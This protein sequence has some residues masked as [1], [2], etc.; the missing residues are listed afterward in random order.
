[1]AGNRNVIS[2]NTNNGISLSGVG[3]T[4]AV[5]QGNFV[6]VTPTGNSSMGNT[7]NGIQVNNSSD[8]LIGGTVTGLGNVISG[9]GQDGIVFDGNANFNVTQG[10][11]IGTN[12]AGTSA[13]GNSDRGILLKGGSSN[14]LIGGTTAGARNIVSGN[15]NSGIATANVN[16]SGNVI[17]GNYIGTNI[18]GSAA[19]GNKR[20]LYIQSD[21]NIIGGAEAGSGNLISGNSMEG[22]RLE[23]S[24]QNTI[25]GNLIGTAASGTAALGN[26]TDGIFLLDSTDTSIGGLVST[27]RNVISGNNNGIYIE[28][29][30]DIRVLGNYI[31]TDI[32]GS[33]D[34]GNSSNGVSLLNTNNNLIGGTSPRARNVISGNDSNG[35]L[36]ADGSGNT[37]Q[38]NFIGTTRTGNAALSNAQNGISLSNSHSNQIGG[39]ASGS[40]NII[41]GNDLMGVNLIDGSSYNVIEGNHI[42]TNVAGTAAVQ[43]DLHGVHLASASHHNRIGGTSAAARNLMSGNGDNGLFLTGDDT[44]YNQVLGNYIGTNAAGTGSISNV[45]GIYIA[46]GASY[47]LV[48]GSTPEA[49][50]VISGNNK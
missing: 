16:T 44:D 5:I 8:N 18:S 25:Q 38:G 26:G 15:T 28:K 14:N 47:N 3:V 4:R 13:I 27:Q 12:A 34:L 7:G 21:G 11:L 17:Q 32:L 35:V 46:S 31:G 50:N 29:G 2:N 20:G 36:I 42:G 1:M 33:A 43:N 48:G 49:R 30:A 37:V 6:G 10:N 41:S 45:N 22:I 9:N 19:L 40:R 24:K 23:N 39:T